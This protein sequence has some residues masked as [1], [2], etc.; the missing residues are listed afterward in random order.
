MKS[1]CKPLAHRRNLHANCLMSVPVFA[2]ILA[3][4]GV[5]AFAE[6]E[7]A[8]WGGTLSRNMVSDEKNIPASWDLET[9]ENIKWTAELGSQSY[10]GGGRAATRYRWKSFRRNK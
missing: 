7:I 9:R 6:T 8:L 1:S 4:T 10:A 2:L 3:F 5:T